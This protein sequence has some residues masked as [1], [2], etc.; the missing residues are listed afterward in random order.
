[1]QQEKFLKIT[2]GQYPEGDVQ[3]SDQK[4]RLRKTSRRFFVRNRRNAQKIKNF[5]Y[6][7]A[8]WNKSPGTLINKIMKL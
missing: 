4:I 6:V 5:V 8:P 7:G 3:S 1:M 2:S